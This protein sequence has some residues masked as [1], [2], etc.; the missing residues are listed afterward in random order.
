MTTAGSAQHNPIGRKSWLQGMTAR[1]ARRAAGGLG[2]TAKHDLH[3]YRAATG[4]FYNAA[5]YSDLNVAAIVGHCRSA[6]A[7]GIV[8][9]VV[10]RTGSTNADLL[11]R[12][13]AGARDASAAMPGPVLLAARRQTA[14]RGRAGRSWQSDAGSLTFSLAW[15]F[16]RPVAGLVGL[17][18]VAGVALAEVLRARGIEVGLTWP[19]VVLLGGRK[20]AGILIETSSAAIGA[21]G[22]VGETAAAGGRAPGTWAVIGIGINLAVEKGGASRARQA[23]GSD[24]ESG[25]SAPLAIAMLPATDRSRLLAEILDALA[26]SL[27]SFDATGFTPWAA[28]WNA[29][30][31]YRDHEVRI[32]DGARELHAG[33]ALGVD[34]AARLLLQTDSGD[35]AVMAGDVS[36]RLMNAA[37]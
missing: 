18:L 14:G 16:A 7:Q 28:R 19:N 4:L 34:A 22:A 10:D 20:L 8:I 11:A 1:H 9:D 37:L 5:M 25:A 29:L 32:L 33:R 36:L 3:G 27:A 2:Q 17:P 31:A 13:A 24:D 26:A 30:H 15:Q 6:D 23:V 35:I 12:I 21:V